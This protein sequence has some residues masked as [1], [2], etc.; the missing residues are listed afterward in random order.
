MNN[1]LTYFEKPDDI[2]PDRL[3][4]L[5]DELGSGKVT[6]VRDGA[7]NFY[8]EGSGFVKQII[9]KSGVIT[10]ITLS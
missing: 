8:T 3:N 7:Y 2:T 10:Q 9:V 1:P 6:P 4:N 5:I